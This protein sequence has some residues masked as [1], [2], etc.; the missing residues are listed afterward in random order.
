MYVSNRGHDSL[1]V[2]RVDAE[3]G[4]LTPAGHALTGGKEPR[5]FAIEPEGKYLLAANQNSNNV[6]VFQ[7]DGETGGLTPT[8]VRVTVPMPVCVEFVPKAP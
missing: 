5:N 2:F 8:G 4:K 7:I 3:S 1:A 6:A